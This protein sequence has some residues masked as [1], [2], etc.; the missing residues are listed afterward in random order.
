MSL[1]IRFDYK[2]ANH[3]IENA[4]IEYMKSQVAT[5]HDLLH[6]R[7]GPGNEYTG[8]LNL[9]NDFDKT[10][11]E[12]IKKVAEKI[13]NNVEV[14]IVIGIGGSYLGAKSAIEVLKN[15]FYNQI[16][17]NSRKAP[18]IYFAGNNISS[19]YLAR[20]VELIKDRDFAI[21]VISKSGTTLEPAIAFRVFRELIEN[22]YGPDGAKERIIA[23]T[24]KSKGAL[25][26]LSDEQG[27]E[28]F[29]VPDNIGGRYSV[30]TAVGLF[31]LAV[32]GIDIDEIMSGAAK[33][34]KEYNNSILTENPCYQYAAI[35][36]IL[37]AKGKSIEL[38]VNYEPD[39]TFFAEWWKQLFGESEGKDNKGI[40]PASANFSTDLHSLGQYI[41]DGRRDLFATTIWVE[42]PPIDMELKPI[43]GDI[44]GLNFLTVKTIHHVNEKAC[45]GAIL[46]HTEGGVPNLKV[47]IPD[48]SPHTYG[49]LVYFF[50][51]ACAISGYILGVNPFDQPGVETYKK[52]MFA[53]LGKPGTEE[54]RKEIERKLKSTHQ[55][56]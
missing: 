26:K 3:F 33:A 55:H 56:A 17:R 53:L 24:D 39:L 22:K 23:T 16:S 54:T 28:T 4:E 38:L 49:Q 15:S 18:E 7:K 20:L 11:Y 42:K 1:G 44:D 41:Q 37:Y 36:N 5:A 51:K 45:Q 46:A 27:Y 35:R 50:E 40:F 31:P 9:P 10:E 2:N 12:R 8:W 21:N 52:N 13:R 19:T 6:N 30:L 29:V 32:A 43:A 47:N 34:Y 25:K 14:F 48:L